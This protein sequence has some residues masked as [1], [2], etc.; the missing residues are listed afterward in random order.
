M[1][2]NQCQPIETAPKDETLVLVFEPRWGWSVASYDS[3]GGEW[4]IRFSEFEAQATHWM[5]L[6]PEPETTV[7]AP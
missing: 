4:R 6:P 5:P 3:N 1:I 7:G 2:A